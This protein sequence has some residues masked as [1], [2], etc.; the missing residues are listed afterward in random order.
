MMDGP[1]GFDAGA[2]ETLVDI[3]QV[4][5][6]SVGVGDMVHPDLATIV[7]RFSA[8]SQHVE[9]RERKSMMLVIVGKKR[10]R[11]I[12]VDDL[13]FEYVAIPRNHLLVPSRHVD[14]VSE[15]DRLHHVDLP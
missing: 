1:I 12:L 6:V 4:T 7:R 11:G 2:L 14:D 8:R 3:K 15:L 10:E 13:R 9:I 5:D